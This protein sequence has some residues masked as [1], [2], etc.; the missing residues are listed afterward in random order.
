MKR[1]LALTF[2]LFIAFGTLQAQDGYEVGD[3]ASDFELKN[4][5]GSMVSMADYEDASGFAV[6][7]TCNHCPYAQAWEQRIINVHEEYADKGYPVIAI[8]PND[9]KL[10]PGDS[11]SRMQE[12]AEEKEYPFPYLFDAEQTV[13]KKYGATKTPH[14]YLLD[15][16]ENGKLKVAY[17]GAVD[18]NYKSAANVEEHYLASAIE[19]LIA[20]K[21]P[22]PR[23]TKAIGCSIKD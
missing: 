18:D 17:I 22:E 9:P 12:R 7:F 3:I 23:F 15:K 20:G 19:A 5:D 4:V 8:N 6:I 16:Q 1:I 11:F 10:S 2:G 13:Y 21:R 14:V